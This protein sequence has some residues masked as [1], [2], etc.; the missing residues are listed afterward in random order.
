MDAV[1]AAL[2]QGSNVTKGLKKVD[3]S[4]MTHK[5]PSLRA[6][7]TRTASSE[8]LSRSRSRGPETKPK[9]VSMRQN[10]TTTTTPTPAKKPAKKELDGNKWLIENWDSPSSP[11]EVE[12][13]LTQSILISRCKNT[14]IILKGKANAI[15]IDNSPRTQLLVESLISSIDVIKSPNFAVQITGALPTIMLDQVD[16]AQIYLGK[17]SLGCEVFTSKCS[18][19]NV[20]LPPDGEEGDSKELPLPEQLR[21]VVRGGEG[22]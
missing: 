11:I 8:E 17:E 12:V 5:N 6:T 7:E 13:S 10:S 20:I 16:G 14:T 2:N 22:C 15:S 19:V 1:F 4:Q 3:K 18:S 9:P 21:T